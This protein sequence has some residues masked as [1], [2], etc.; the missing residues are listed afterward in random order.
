ME[1]AHECIVILLAIILLILVIIIVFSINSHKR[2]R[3]RSTIKI[4]I[5]LYPNKRTT[6]QSLKLNSK[7]ELNLL[8]D[9]SKFGGFCYERKNGKIHEIWLS[10]EGRRFVLEYNKNTFTRRFKSAIKWLCSVLLR[11]LPST[12]RTM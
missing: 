2:T 1:F 3:H 12:F 7:K 6:I 11:L 5:G 9:I 4:M 8:R 10:S